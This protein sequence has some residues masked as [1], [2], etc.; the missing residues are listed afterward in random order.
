MNANID[1]D[2]G[3][4]IAICDQNIVSFGKDVKKVFEEA[5]KQQR[6]LKG[7]PLLTWVPDKEPIDDFLRGKF[8]STQSRSMIHS[9]FAKSS[10]SRHKAPALTFLEKLFATMT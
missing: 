2:V 8:C 4:W 5:K 9:N 6:C 10:R 1:S 3:Q 7:T